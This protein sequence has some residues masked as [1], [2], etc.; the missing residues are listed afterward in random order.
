MKPY[1][2][3]GQVTLYHGD[4]LEVL[5]ALPDASLDC[6]LT[7]PPYCSGASLEAQKNT[8]AQGLRSATVQ[9]AGFRWFAADNMSTAGLMALLRSLLIEGRRVLRP[10]R[11]AFVFTDWRM[12]PIMAPALEASGLRY[13]NLLVWDKGSPG[14]GNGFK[15]AHELVMEFT[16]GSTEYRASMGRTSSAPPRRV[17]RERARAQ[18]PVTL[19]ARSCALH[20][21]GRRARSLV[22][23]G[24]RPRREEPYGPSIGPTSCG[25]RGRLR[26]E[27]LT[28]SPPPLAQAVLPL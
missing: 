7:D 1:F 17:R 19:L 16:N 25:D 8:P 3:D 22:G 14:L 5:A 10:D 4:A 20:P 18:K 28:P 26:P 15:P 24:R 13:R 11:S 9:A 2:D 27:V 23:S 21:P 12:V 6:I